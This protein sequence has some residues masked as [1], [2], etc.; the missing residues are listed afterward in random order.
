MS[1]TV[2]GEPTVGKTKPETILRQLTTKEG[3]VFLMGLEGLLCSKLYLFH[4][5]IDVCGT[6]TSFLCSFDHIYLT[7]LLSLHNLLHTWKFE[8][9]P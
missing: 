7:I 2:S 4:Y 6:I 5:F 1:L 8:V 3:Q 9:N